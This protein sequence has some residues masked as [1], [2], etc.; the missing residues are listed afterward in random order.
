VPKIFILDDQISYRSQIEKRIA[1]LSWLEVVGSSRINLGTLNLLASSGADV[2]VIE[3]HPGSQAGMKI[4]EDV[5]QTTHEIKTVIALVHETAQTARAQSLGASQVFCKKL[6]AE[7][8]E[9][10]IA[11]LIAGALL[12]LPRPQTIEVPTGA[13]LHR[14]KG[15][16][17]EN[18]SPQAIVIASSTGGPPVLERIFSL[19]K[20]PLL[21]PVFLVQHMPEFFTR[22][23]A[24]RLSTVSGLKV[25]EA[26]DGEEVQAGTCY[27]APGNF[28]MQLVNTARKVVIRLN[29]DEK[30]HSVRPAADYLFSTAAAIYTRDCLG[31]V[32]TGMGMDGANGALEIRKLGGH[33]VIQD[34]ESSAV[35]GMPGAAHAL[36]A[37]DAM[38][39]IDGIASL[40]RSSIARNAS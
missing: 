15:R 21:I 1:A 30:L 37:F 28:H 12:A 19:L 9:V 20:P 26:I 33:V 2:L 25:R 40:L 4:L 16:L 29:Q 18:W 35:W 23:L 31:I 13:S 7:A 14:P 11:G 17:A 5:R 34:K 27:V 32:L 36:G 10:R 8:D 3:L 39:D 22:E 24:Q 38:E 6:G